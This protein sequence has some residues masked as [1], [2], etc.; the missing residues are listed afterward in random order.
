MK[1]ALNRMLIAAISVAACGI[2]ILHVYFFSWADSL[3]VHASYLFATVV[4]PPATMLI[5]GGITGFLLSQRRPRTR[6]VLLLSGVGVGTATLQILYLY[7]R[8]S[9][10]H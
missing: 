8:L 7:W 6:D 5:I 10:S 4:I 9:Q 1:P 3:A 2:L